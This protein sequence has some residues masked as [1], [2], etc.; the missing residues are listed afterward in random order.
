[1]GCCKLGDD[2]ANVNVIV[3]AADLPKAKG[4]KVYGS[5]EGLEFCKNSKRIYTN[6][7]KRIFFKKSEVNGGRVN[8]VYRNDIVQIAILLSPF[9]A[10]TNIIYIQQDKFQHVATEQNSIESL[11]YEH[12]HVCTN[13]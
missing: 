9:D 10:T 13:Y 2:E 7:I 1:M 3:E 5:V 12:F 8:D 11:R 6:R 4:R